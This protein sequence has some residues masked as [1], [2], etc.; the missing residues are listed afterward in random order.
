ML[1]LL[2]RIVRSRPAR[3]DDFMSDAELGELP[4]LDSEHARL[5]T[6]ISTFNTEQ[7]ARR[8]AQAYPMLGRFIATIA[9]PE[10]ATVRV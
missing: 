10:D 1:R 8:K 7:Q 4:P 3:V 5:H 6:G 2:Y 9:L